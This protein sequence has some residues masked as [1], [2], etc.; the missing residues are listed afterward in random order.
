MKPRR[1][2]ELAA[3]CTLC[4]SVSDVELVWTRRGKKAS[5]R[6]PDPRVQMQLAQFRLVNSS[7]SSSSF[8]ETKLE[9]VFECRVTNDTVRF[10]DGRLMVDVCWSID[11]DGRC[12][13]GNGWRFDGDE[14]IGAGD[15]TARWLESTVCWW[16]HVST[17]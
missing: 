15:V 4:G 5:G 2:A 11:L 12:R 3:M 14:C 13:C 8:V 9:C 1:S 6:K 7:S 16:P 10:G 17:T